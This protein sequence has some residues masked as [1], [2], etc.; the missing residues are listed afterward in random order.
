MIGFIVWLIIGLLIISSGIRS[1]IIK[2]PFNFLIER[3]LTIKNYKK[4]NICMGILWVIS[5]I[6]II[7]TGL[8]FILN[9]ELI[10]SVTMTLSV[11]TL[12]VLFVGSTLLMTHFEKR[13]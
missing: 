8:P 4:Y 12:I 13:L 3:V 9:K 2:E 6:F 5:G 7:L 11:L 10:I 1:F